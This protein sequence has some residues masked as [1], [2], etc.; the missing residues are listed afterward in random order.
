MPHITELKG[1]KYDPELE[2]FLSSWSWRFSD[3]GYVVRSGK[4]RNKQFIEPHRVKMHRAIWEHVHGECP[5]ILDHINRDKTDNR[6]CNLRAVTHQ[7]NCL[8][9]SS[10]NCHKG[11]L[12]DGTWGWRTDIGDKKRPQE[13]Y[14]KTHKTF[15]DA[16]KDARETKGRFIDG[17]R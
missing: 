8:N 2:E 14:R 9:T 10:L 4:K 13:R 6:L 15:C 1:V 17:C 16:F 3:Q 12:K 5:P 7:Q 11:Y